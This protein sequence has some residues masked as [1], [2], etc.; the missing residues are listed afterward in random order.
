[1]GLFLDMFYAGDTVLI[2]DLGCANYLSDIVCIDKWGIGTLEIGQS[3][4]NGSM[5]VDMLRI[6]AAERNVKVA[7]LYVDGFIP[8]EWE[9]VGRWTIRDNVVTSNST[10]SFFAVMPSER[11]RLVDNLALFSPYLAEDVI[12]SGIYT[13]LI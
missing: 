9:E 1:M 6:I 11:D 13:S 4:L 2:N 10:V 7:I 8:E 3:L 5:S 12:E